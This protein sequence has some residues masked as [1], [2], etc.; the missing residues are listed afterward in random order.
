MEGDTAKIVMIYI[1]ACFKKSSE[2]TFGN[3]IDTE[4]GDVV[5]ISFL[6]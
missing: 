5:H 2:F 4:K 1:A 3:G 6:S